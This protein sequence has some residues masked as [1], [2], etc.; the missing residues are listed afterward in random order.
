MAYFR[1]ESR[2]PAL[3]KALNKMYLSLLFKQKTSPVTKALLPIIGP[4]F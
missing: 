4:K 3:G 2:A 1:N